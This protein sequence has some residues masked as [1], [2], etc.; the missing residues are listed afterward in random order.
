M[1]SGGR[2]A[3]RTSVG[4]FFDVD[5]TILAENSG[6]AYLKTLYERGEIDWKAVLLGLGTYLRYKLNLLDIERWVER[7]SVQFRGRSEAAL[8][9]EAA[10]LFRSVLFPSIYPEAEA[11]VRWHLGQG[12]LV[13]LV[14]GATKFVL[15]PLA[16]HLGVKHML[17]TLLETHD[18]VFTG[19]VIRPICFGEGKI[20]WIQQ[21][22]ERES[23]DLAR[24][25]FY[26]DSITDLPLLDLVG[27][28]VVVNP[29]PLL[30]RHALS[31]HW[32]VRFFERPR[33]VTS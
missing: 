13:A 14:S 20:Y 2:G 28:P 9:Q 1:S 5:K 24:S 31:R 17:C 16:E 18:G 15:E 6:T 10:E 12:H 25:F 30:Y 26:T 7:N 32:P 8:A 11:R 22:I 23:I 33:R 27:H 29:D 4:A 19:R 21:L 3:R